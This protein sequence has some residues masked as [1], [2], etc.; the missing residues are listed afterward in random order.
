MNRKIID[1]YIL[2]LYLTPLL[3][4]LILIVCKLE[5]YKTILSPVSND[6]FISL[7]VLRSSVLWT[8]FHVRKD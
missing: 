7:I 4:F 3:K 8:S 5:V 6:N 2:I 1:F